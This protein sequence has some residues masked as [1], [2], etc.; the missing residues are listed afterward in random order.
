MVVANAA[1]LLALFES[2][3]D[4]ANTAELFNVPAAA[5]VTTIA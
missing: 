4:P 5:G 1:E 2:A 3:G